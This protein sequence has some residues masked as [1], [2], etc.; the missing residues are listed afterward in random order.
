V[1]VRDGDRTGAVRIVEHL[2]E[3]LRRTLRRH[4]A[5]EVTLK[6][7]LELVR[8]YLAIEQA[9][10]SDRLR[11]EFAIEESVLAAAVPS[12]ALQHLVENAIR[13]GIARRPEAGR[14]IVAARRDGDT[15]ELSVSDDGPGY[16]E[17]RGTVKGRG[18]DNTRERLRALHGDRASLVIVRGE[19]G[20]TIATLRVPYREM[21]EEAHD[22]EA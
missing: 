17:Q 19:T 14:V 7:E 5:N 13:H 10:F 18:I 3:L 21:A 9:R 22:G 8:Q 12:F 15:L 4:R 11:P 2:S 20:G 16:D 1:L 6:E